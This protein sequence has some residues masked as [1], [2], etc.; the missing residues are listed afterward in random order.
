MSWHKT[1]VEGKVMWERSDG[2][3]LSRTEDIDAL[4][5]AET[6]S[7][8][9]RTPH[10]RFTFEKDDGYEEEPFGIVGQT[11]LLVL[12]VSLMIFMFIVC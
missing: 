8:K 7:L 5:R 9:K 6:E 10:P 1:D 2:V 11:I 3:R 12:I 4:E